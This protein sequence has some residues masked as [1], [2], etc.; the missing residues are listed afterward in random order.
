M[1]AFPTLTKYKSNQTHEGSQRKNLY[2]VHIPK[3][4]KMY[5]RISLTNGFI[6]KF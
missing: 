2:M 3:L 4:L 5:L 1:N 6:Q